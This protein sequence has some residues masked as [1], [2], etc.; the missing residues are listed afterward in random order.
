M[1]QSQPSSPT[2]NLAGKMD[3]S[4][5][6]GP[7]VRA[8]IW[9]QGCTLRCPG[10]FN[11]AFQSQQGGI[12]TPLLEIMA[13]LGSIPGIEGVSISGGEPTD[14]MAGVLSLVRDIRRTTG[15]TIL[16]FSGRIMDVIQKMPGGMELIALLDVLV[17][18]PYDPD[19]ANPWGVWPSSGNQGIRLL[20]GRYRMTDFEGISPLEFQIADTGVVV[21]SGMGIFNLQEETK[22]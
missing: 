17:D 20:S 4:R 15:L 18:G 7:G 16:L 9:V 22:R 13:W 14:Q 10:C 21:M 11:P 8:V 3:R 1:R 12:E 19:R 5:S 6:N 2:L